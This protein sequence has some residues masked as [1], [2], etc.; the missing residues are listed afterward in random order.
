MKEVVENS[1]K[2]IR[3]HSAVVPLKISAIVYPLITSV[4]VVGSY[5]SFHRILSTIF[6]NVSFDLEFPV[7]LRL[8]LLDI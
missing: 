7:A 3:I 2:L 8:S 6:P 1:S 4:E 5:Q